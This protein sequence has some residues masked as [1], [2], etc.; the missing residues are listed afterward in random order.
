MSLFVE[1]VF[2]IHIYLGVINC[3][4]GAMNVLTDDD[5][6]SW[7]GKADKLL[8]QLSSNEIYLSRAS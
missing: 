2:T 7:L 4:A 8:T 6:P 3:R 1:K 5:P